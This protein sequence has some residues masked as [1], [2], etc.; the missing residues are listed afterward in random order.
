M[1]TLLNQPHQTFEPAAA[2]QIARELQADDPDWVYVV[3]HDPAGTGR[4][5][6]DIFDE[7]GAFVAML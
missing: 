2:E 3:R 1:L 4:S 7:Q 5:V 6:I